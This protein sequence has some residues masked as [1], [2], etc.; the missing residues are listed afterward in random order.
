VLSFWYC[1]V[2]APIPPPLQVAASLQRLNKFMGAELMAVPQRVPLPPVDVATKSMPVVNLG[3]ADFSWSVSA[4]SLPPPI[5]KRRAFGLWR[6]LDGS[7][8]LLLS[9]VV[10]VVGCGDWAV[11]AGAGPGPGRPSWAAFACHNSLRA[12]SCGVHMVSPPPISLLLQRTSTPVLRNIHLSVPRGEF[13]AV[14]GQ[15]GAGKSSLLAAILGG[16]CGRWGADATEHL[17]LVLQ[18]MYGGGSGVSGG[19]GGGAATHSP[20]QSTRNVRTKCS[21]LRTTPCSFRAL[22]VPPPLPPPSHPPVELHC[23]Q[24]GSD[25]AVNV[26]NLE[27]GSILPRIQGRVAYVAQSAFILNATLRDNVMFGQVNDDERFER[28]I[29]VR[30]MGVCGGWGHGWC[31]TRLHPLCCCYVCWQGLGWHVC[32]LCVCSIPGDPLCCLVTHCA[33]W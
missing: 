29:A 11:C 26:G 19:S 28:A 25:E 7:C 24:P 32:G 5:P 31:G 23:R 17:P 16:A 9:G 20:L 14:V 27:H 22:P 33:V 18:A 3:P 1:V 4:T 2:T 13:W 8:W 12:S 6:A 21:S 15:V 30:C 10:A